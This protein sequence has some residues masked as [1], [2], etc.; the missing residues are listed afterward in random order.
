MLHATAEVR[1]EA[2]ALESPTVVLCAGGTP[3]RPYE[4]D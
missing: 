4:P 2:V 3:G 1:R